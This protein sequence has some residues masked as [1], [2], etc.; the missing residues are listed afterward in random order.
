MNY[1]MISCKKKQQHLFQSVNNLK[2]DKEW[3][4]QHDND[5]KHTAAIVK[6]WLKKEWVE[7]LKWSPFSLDMNPIEHLWDGVEKRTTSQCKRIERE[8]T[9]SLDR[10]REEDLEEIGGF[11]S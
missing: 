5:T 6:N 9:S 2:M 4:F 3:G 1:A 10:N 11:Y 7:Q 8:S